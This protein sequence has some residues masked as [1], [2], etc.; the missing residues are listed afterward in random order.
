MVNISDET[1]NFLAPPVLAAIR[2]GDIAARVRM[3]RSVSQEIREERADLIQAAEQS[4]NVI[5]DLG[6]DGVVRWV[7]PSWKDVVGTPLE[8]VQG[9]PITNILLDDA[10]PFPGAIDAMKRDDSK[11]QSVRFRVLLGQ[12]SLFKHTVSRPVQSDEAFASDQE[13]LVEGEL[14]QS[15]TLEGQGILVNDLSSGLLAEEESHVRTISLISP[16]KE[17]QC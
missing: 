8:S 6:P 14:A 11:S 7:S 10:N 4:L 5:I 2:N 15:V 1:T 16:L 3:E 9:R 17:C 13:A 12:S